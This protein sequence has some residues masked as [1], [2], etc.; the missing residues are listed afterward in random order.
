MVVALE[1]LC[2][3]RRRRLVVN[4]L[5]EAVRVVGGEVSIAVISYSD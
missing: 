1:Y 5:S 4:A 3:K 2:W